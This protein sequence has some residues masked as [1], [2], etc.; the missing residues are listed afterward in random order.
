[1]PPRLYSLFDNAPVVVTRTAAGLAAKGKTTWVVVQNDDGG[2]AGIGMGCLSGMPER[3][4]DVL[5][6][7]YDNQVYMNMGVQRPRAT[8]PMVRT[9]ATQS[10]GPN[11]GSRSGQGEN[12]ARAV[13]AHEISYV[14][15]TTATDP[16]DPEHK[17]KKV[18]SYHGAC[19]IYALVPCPL[20]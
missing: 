15:A 11:P 1:M 12:M 10:V 9:V 4:D 16:R 20:G 18:M 5:H 17:V 14:V 8:P 3:N 6:I 2:T 7:C 13:T 19:Y